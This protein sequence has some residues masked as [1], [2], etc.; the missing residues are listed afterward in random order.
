IGVR[1]PQGRDRALE[2][3][4]HAFLVVHE[5]LLQRGV[6]VHLAPA[7]ALSVV[8]VHL[9]DDVPYLHLIVPPARRRQAGQVVEA[10]DPGL[11]VVPRHDAAELEEA[12]V[13]PRVASLRDDHV[14]GRVGWRLRF[15][16]DVPYLV[17]VSGHRHGWARTIV[18]GTHRPDRV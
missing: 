5:E 14:V 10:P 4:G 16:D 15:L 2:Y 1:R 12:D 11:A 3:V 18:I 17:G 6:R 9:A 7:P 13:G 8:V